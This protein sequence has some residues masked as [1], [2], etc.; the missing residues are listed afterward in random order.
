MKRGALCYAVAV[1][2]AIATSAAPALAQH[3]GHGG[4]GFHGGGYHYVPQY[5][6]GGHHRGGGWGPGAAIGLGLLG[7]GIAGAIASQPS[8]CTTQTGWYWDGYQQVPIYQQ[9]AC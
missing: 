7:L 9:Y 5:H 4:G 3:R 2:L 6:G 1:A 8:V